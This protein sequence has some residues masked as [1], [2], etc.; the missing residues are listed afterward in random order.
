MAN[1][2]DL[3]GLVTGQFGVTFYTDSDAQP[4]V[5][6]KDVR[7][8]L[9][10][11][12]TT[13]RDAIDGRRLENNMILYNS[14]DTEYQIYT[15]GTRQ[16][17]GFLTGG[18]WR[19]LYLPVD[20]DAVGA[21]QINTPQGRTANTVLHLDTDADNN[22]ILSWRSAGTQSI[23]AG[24]ITRD[25]LNQDVAGAGL[26]KPTMMSGIRVDTDFGLTFSTNQNDTDARLRVDTDV[27]A[28]RDYVTQNTVSNIGLFDTDNDGLAPRVTDSENNFRHYLRGDQR[29]AEQ[30]VSGDGIEDTIVLRHNTL[31]AGIK[32]RG[33]MV[34]SGSSSS[35]NGLIVSILQPDGLYQSTDPLTTNQSGDSDQLVRVLRIAGPSFTGFL[36]NLAGIR[37][38]RY[39]DLESAIEWDYTT[40]GPLDTDTDLVRISGITGITVVGSILQQGLAPTDTN[41]GS[42]IIDLDTEYM[43][44]RQYARIPFTGASNVPPDTIRFVFSGTLTTPFT[45]QTPGSF[46]FYPNNIDNG[47]E[48]VAKVAAN[49]TDSESVRDFIHSSYTSINDINSIG[50]MTTEGTD[51]I[52]LT[53]G[54]TSNPNLTRAFTSGVTDFGIDGLNQDSDD[55]FAGI[56]MTIMASNFSNILTATGDSDSDGASLIARDRTLNNLF[57]FSVGRIASGTPG[58]VPAPDSDQADLF[59][60]GD[61]TWQQ[62]R[63]DDSDTTYT[64]STSDTDNFVRI[65]GSDGS[66]SAANIG[67]SIRV[68]DASGPGFTGKTVEHRRGDTYDTDHLLEGSWSVYGVDGSG[69][70]IDANTFGTNVVTLAVDTDYIADTDWVKNYVGNHAGV[71]D[72]D[73]SA[74]YGI[75]IRADS[76]RHTINVDTDDIATRTYATYRAGDG[77]IFDTDDTDG[78]NRFTIDTE[79]PHGVATRQYVEDRLED[80]N[81]ILNIFDTDRDGLVPRPTPT[82]VN[83]RF[84]LSAD[85]EWRSLELTQRA[86]DSEKRISLRTQS[87]GARGRVRVALGGFGSINSAV[88]VRS[89]DSDTEDSVLI[90]TSAGTPQLVTQI[91]S[92]NPDYLGSI[93]NITNIQYN[94]PAA[95]FE[96]E[97]AVPGPVPA[98]PIFLR[99]QQGITFAV[100]TTLEDGEPADDT[101]YSVVAITPFTDS[102]GSIVGLVPAP[103]NTRDRNDVLYVD[104]WGPNGRAGI[105]TFNTIRDRNTDTDNTWYRGQIVQVVGNEIAGRVRGANPNAFITFRRSTFV[106]DTDLIVMQ[107]V[108]QALIDQYVR[109]GAIIS[110]DSDTDSQFIIDSIHTIFPA[111]DRA[112]VNVRGISDSYVLNTDYTAFLQTEIQSANRGLYQ[113]IGPDRTQGAT[114][115]SDWYFLTGNYSS[116]PKED[117]GTITARNENS[118]IQWKIGDFVSVGE[119][120][121]VYSG[122]TAVK[123]N[124]QIN[125]DQLEPGPTETIEWTQIGFTGLKGDTIQDVRYY[126]DQ[127]LTGFFLPGNVLIPFGSMM[128]SNS[129]LFASSQLPNGGNWSDVRSLRF[130]LRDENNELYRAFSAIGS[131]SIITIES[132]DGID[133]A[134]WTIASRS[135]VDRFTPDTVLIRELRGNSRGTYRHG[136]R[137]KVIAL[138]V[139]APIASESILGKG[140]ITSAS[141]IAGDGTRVPF[142][143]RPVGTA[144]TSLSYANG[145]VPAIRT[146]PIVPAPD[147]YVSTTGLNLNI[148]RV[149]N[150]STIQLAPDQWAYVDDT[151]GNDQISPVNT[152]TWNWVSPPG[153]TRIAMIMRP[154]GISFDTDVVGTG[155]INWANSGIGDR[156]M[157]A[158]RDANN[159]A[160]F[161][162]ASIDVVEPN[163]IDTEDGG[164]RQL[165]IRVTG[166]PSLQIGTPVLRVSDGNRQ[167]QFIFGVPINGFDTDNPGQYPITESFGLTGSESDSDRAGYYLNAS[168]NWTLIDTTVASTD[169]DIASVMNSVSSNQLT[170]TLRTVGGRDIPSAAV[171]LGAASGVTQDILDSEV[172]RFDSEIGRLGL[173]ITAE[174]E[175]NIH[176]SLISHN[177]VVHQGHPGSVARY[178]VTFYGTGTGTYSNQ[179]FH[180]PVFDSEVTFGPANPPQGGLG[181]ANYLTLALQN[182][183]D[184]FT[185]VVQNGTHV[186]W[187]ATQV[188]Y[189]SGQI[190][191]G[192]DLAYARATGFVTRGSDS[193][194]TTYSREILGGVDLPNVDSELNRTGLRETR[195]PNYVRLDVE[196]HNTV[197]QEGHPGQ[198]AIATFTL[199]TEDLL[200]GTETYVFN[201]ADTEFTATVTNPATNLIAISS[202]AT[203]MFNR[204]GTG[205]TDLFSNV[206]VQNNTITYTE[207]SLLRNDSDTP[208][209][210]TESRIG[211][212]ILENRF[213]SRGITFLAHRETSRIARGTDIQVFDT[214][215]GVVPGATT[216]DIR[217]RRLL[218]ADGT[219]YDI[220]D[221]L[222]TEFSSIREAVAVEHDYAR[223]HI[224]GIPFDT[225]TSV[226]PRQFSSVIIDSEQTT[227]TIL[228][229][230]SDTWSSFING[231]GQRLLTTQD[232]SLRLQMT[233]R[234]N[235]DNGFENR[236]LF[237]VGVDSFTFADGTN[238]VTVTYNNGD[239]ILEGRGQDQ[240]G[241]RVTSRTSYTNG[242]YFVGI[243]GYIGTVNSPIFYITDLGSF[244]EDAYEWTPVEPN[245]LFI[246][247]DRNPNHFV[248]Q[249]DTIVIDNA[250]ERGSIKTFERTLRFADLDTDPGQGGRHVEWVN[251]SLVSIEGVDNFTFDQLQLA[252]TIR[253]TS[254]G[255]QPSSDGSIQGGVGFANNLTLKIYD[256]AED[257]DVQTLDFTFATINGSAFP[258]SDSNNF[259]RQVFNVNFTSSRTVT[260]LDISHQYLVRLTAHLNYSGGS[261]WGISNLDR[262]LEPPNAY[263]AEITNV[264]SSLTASTYNSKRLIGSDSDTQHPFASVGNRSP[265]I[266]SVTLFDGDADEATIFAADADIRDSIL[267]AVVTWNGPTP[268]SDNPVIDNP[269]NRFEAA[270]NVETAITTITV[271]HNIT[272][273]FNTDAYISVDTDFVSDVPAGEP[274]TRIYSIVASPPIFSARGEYV[275]VITV[276]AVHFGFRVVQYRIRLSTNGDDIN[277]SNQRI[278]KIFRKLA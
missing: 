135:T 88:V 105:N 262:D 65:R 217:D 162:I 79:H 62:V 150:T 210:V 180:I 268:D 57:P 228:P 265:R 160:V 205:A 271:P 207:S 41:F 46:N 246:T 86:D 21:M 152:T 71:I 15:G 1:Q 243:V 257:T 24:S 244:G 43:A 13:E 128:V 196:T 51:T 111:T 173:E 68:V 17:N 272:D 76:D 165:Q 4:M 161:N 42:T 140:L 117:F 50:T 89:P 176:V 54:T 238:T 100:V 184:R 34:F 121:Y 106:G 267:T 22:F 97:Y 250:L 69:I 252:I 7:G 99:N 132:E 185:N 74:G 149:P 126:T 102:D 147:N 98:N 258:V 142:T 222:D 251:D 170:T 276:Q 137:Y 52:V 63:T 249:A 218:A 193:D 145:L 38:V 6:G 178:R 273:Y 115:D 171:S 83:H 67:F 77:L 247:D 216:T 10:S 164:P 122:P 227:F 242:G 201:L 263:S 58:A 198:G 179:I 131:G 174:D 269:V 87:T 148:A 229:Q 49:L 256:V 213:L 109:P 125:S 234:N 85:R 190:L 274:R 18:T 40:P 37:N 48:T 53:A 172:A 33:R 90:Q 91:L 84:H 28:T 20:S 45:T 118:T 168:G 113:Y 163:F 197:L 259:S 39:I 200:V 231:Q 23:S 3:Q 264:I 129:D 169:S 133:Y 255:L 156:R 78:I 277:L 245:S 66:E 154:R 101:E 72:T 159:W 204:T 64:I 19:T 240:F 239:A 208:L 206:D 36:N 195:H 232:N 59:L 96:F 215:A 27:I 120:V 181:G 253:T 226:S 139:E 103:G 235:A 114:T 31:T 30:V 124:Q 261:N 75:A 202:I 237:I 151:D 275:G 9:A 186:T 116:P 35:Y 199:D 166:N 104:G 146:V 175:N 70:E 119:E 192:P 254:P 112:D 230:D 95:Y 141:H 167:T 183:T 221:T 110:S 14:T 248:R 2:T 55:S 29:W 236:D 219:W 138:P 130:A 212:A 220:H 44:T 203:Q 187:D 26:I 194:E 266:Q 270:E 188:G 81:F 143:A 93:N 155:L 60:R 107:N 92:L 177:S 82:E 209:N 136:T 11:Y 233:F 32:A 108:N 211:W 241:Q 73:I 182:R 144:D 214:D 80:A 127:N 8:G 225:E 56:T 25:L 278:R 191:P 123:G 158:Y 223:T 260:G 47:P 5:L 94:L 16:T 189:V 224:G 157:V 12:T 134:S 153:P 61:G